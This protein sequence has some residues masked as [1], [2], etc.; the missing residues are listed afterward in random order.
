M[1]SPPRSPELLSVLAG[2]GTVAYPFLVYFGLPHLAPV[3]LVVLAGCLGGLHLLRRRRLGHSLMPGWAFLLIPCVLVLLLALRP[4][5]AVQAYPPL[6]SL[7]LAAA[8]AWSLA[9]PPSAIERLARLTNPDL[10][11]EAIAYTRTVTK[12]W[13]AFFLANATIAIVCAV[14]FSVA[15]WAL[16]DR[17]R[18]LPGDRR[19]V[20]RRGLVPPL[21]AAAG[22][23]VST[24]AL[25][26]LFVSGRDPDTVVAM[27]GRTPLRFGPVRRRRCAHGG[28]RAC[29]RRGAR[30]RARRG[31]LSLPGRRVRPLHAGATVIV[32]PDG[33]PDTL[34]GLR[35]NFDALLSDQAQ[36]GAWPI[37]AAHGTGPPPGR[38]DPAAARLEFF[39][40]GSTG[41]AKRVVR[42]LAM[43]DREVATLD[44]VWGADM[45]AGLALSTV[46]HR[47]IFGLSFHVL[48]PL[49]SSRPFASHV[50]EL[51]EDLLAR[52]I[53]GG[54]L[55]TSPAH[56]MR[57]GG[58]EPLPPRRR[59]AHVF[60]AGAPLGAAHAQ[61][62]AGVL[63]VLPI[64]IFGSTETGAIATR[65]QHAGM[66]P[67]Q[68]LPG[69]QVRT[70]AA[71]CMVVQSPYGPD[72]GPFIS[73][74]RIEPLPDGR[75]HFLGR[76]DRIAKIEGNRVSLARLEHELAALPWVDDAAAVVI[77]SSPERLAAVV[78][79][80]AEGRAMLDATGAFRF[81]RVLRRE[82][83][84]R[85]E[86]AWLPKS[87]RFVDTLPSGTMGKRRDA[88]IR[89][90]FLPRGRA[91]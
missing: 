89:A 27:R 66:E 46:P 87:W 90:L 74:D 32:P 6:V 68:P 2:V 1:R 75:F 62:A 79:V 84:R 22:G 39:T 77:G 41:A 56:L 85:L 30:C 78:A 33:L 29:R 19:A 18:L 65:R 71:G 10:P 67:W 8:F 12:V 14:A 43:F 91:P 44:A 57:L 4:V 15:V 31:S 42:S 51:W 17:L 61:E 5:L 11:P 3:V 59:P 48:W 26:D 21:E 58:I 37:E 13:I 73:A 63:G 64:E 47:H 55:I 76:A 60:T 69:I 7:S 25:G 9:R 23:G 24:V 86:H 35:G 16:V 28:C 81:S 40:S 20:C 80:N 38:I 88:D 50:D 52:D 53:T 54:A 45:H 36:P 34:A 82:L 83:S 49:A 70:D 72:G